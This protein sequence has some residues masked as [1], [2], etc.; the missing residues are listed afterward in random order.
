[1]KKRFTDIDDDIDDGW[2]LWCGKETLSPFC[3]HLQIFFVNSWTKKAKGLDAGRQFVVSNLEV[4]H[5][6]YF[7]SL[8]LTNYIA[9]WNASDIS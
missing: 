3:P 4:E 9:V 7:Q 8:F 5:T 1:M 6:M 2:L